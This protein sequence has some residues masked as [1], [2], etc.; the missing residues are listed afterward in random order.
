MAKEQ[1]GKIGLA[2]LRASVARATAV[3]DVVLNLRKH[4]NR[5]QQYP[6]YLEILHICAMRVAIYCE[7]DS[8]MVMYHVILSTIANAALDPVSD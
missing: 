2:H 1:T 6:V 5:S 7:A 4:L 3:T 8:D